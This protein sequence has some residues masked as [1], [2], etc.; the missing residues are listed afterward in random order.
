MFQIFQSSLVL[1]NEVLSLF[2]FCMLSYR[3]LSQISFVENLVKPGTVP[4]KVL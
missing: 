1:L 2:A 4:D 3:G